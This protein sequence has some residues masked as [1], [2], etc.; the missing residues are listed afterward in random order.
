MFIID[1]I[2]SD[3]PYSSYVRSIGSF[4]LQNETTS[5]AYVGDLGLHNNRLSMLNS[6]RSVSL[7]TNHRT[8]R[9]MPRLVN[10][11]KIH[12]IWN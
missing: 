5:E 1:I 9:H 12:E 11:Q 8:V 7:S 10:K 2:Q 4:P 6:M 3:E